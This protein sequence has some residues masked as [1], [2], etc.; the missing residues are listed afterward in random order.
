[1]STNILGKFI[2]IV[3]ILVVMTLSAAWLVS[4]QTVR[5]I[6]P[7]GLATS[8]STSSNLTLIAATAL[9]LTATTTNCTARIVSTKNDSPFGVML[10]FRDRDEPTVINGILQPASTT[11]AY[12]GGIYGCG[13]LKAF[14][15]V[16]Q[17]ID[18]LETK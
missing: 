14:S 11:V 9:T 10:T 2:A 5:A 4:F 18:I 6:A 13:A 15:V 7:A 17:G 3:L 16:G 1:M 8:V 12:D